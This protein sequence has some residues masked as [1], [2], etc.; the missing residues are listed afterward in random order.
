MLPPERTI[1]ERY[2]II[3]TVDERPGCTVYR[4]RDEQTNR[5]MLMA[6]LL[7]AP[8]DLEDLRLLVRQVVTVRHEMILP[9]LDHFAE[10]DRYYVVCEDV[11]GQDLERTLRAQGGP[12]SEADG[13]AQTRQLL[14]AL[15]YIHNQR[16]A[17]FLADPFTSDIL[18]RDDGA[19]RLTPFTMIRPLSHTPSPYRAPE[20]DQSE[21]EPTPTSDLYA[22]T[23][24]LYY[25]LTG[26]APPTPAQRQAGM[27]LTG[28]RSLNPKLASLTEQVVLRGL[29]LKPENR[30]QVPTEMRMSLDM[31]QLMAG[32]SLGADAPLPAVAPQLPYPPTPSA[33]PPLIVPPTS[34]AAQGMPAGLPPP[35]APMGYAAPPP[36][37]TIPLPE[38][39][40]LPQTGPPASSKNALRT[41]CLVA[42]A[43]GLALAAIA[44]CAA[45]AW[46]IPG[47]PLPGLLGRTAPSAVPVPQVAEATPLPELATPAESAA[48]AEAM[49]GA[50]TAVALP[51]LEPL[52]LGPR[53]IT[54]QSAAQITQTRV[55]TS[56][57]V[58]PVAFAPDGSIL[59]V[60]VSNVIRLRDAQTLADF[61][62]PR[63][64]LGHTGKLFTL[65]FSPDGKLLASGAID[66]NT[67][68]LW[69]AATGAQVRTLSGHN[70]WIRIVAF[71]PDGK[72]LASG[73]FDTSI[74]LW[75][76]ASGQLIRTLQ[77]HS[78]FISTV[79]FSPDGKFLASSASDGTVQMWDL[80][81]G[82]R[83]DGFSF[84]TTPNPATGKPL[85]TTGLA[86]SPDGKTLAVG[87]EDGS[88][89]LADAATGSIPRTLRGHTSI[90]V[91]RALQFSP[92]GTT[93]ASGS[94]DGTVRLWDIATGT[95]QAVLQG[96]GLRV[97][98]VAFSPDGTHLASTSD[99]G[100]QLLLWDVATGRVERSLR[101]GQGVVT[102]LHF[103]PDGTILG[104]V[105]YNGATHMHL[106]QQKQ[107]RTLIGSPL[108]LNSL[109]FLDNRHVASIADDGTV[110]LLDLSAGNG[111][112]LQGAEGNAVNLAAS[113]DGTLLA[114]GSD[115]GA[116]MRWNGTNGQPQPVLHGKLG[117]VYALAVS[118]DGG[119][120][121]AAGPARDPQIEIWDAVGGKLLH[122]IPADNGSAIA[123]VF[124]PRGGALAVATAEGKLQLW[125]AR[126]GALAQ[127][128][129]VPPEQGRF[130]ALAFSPDGT[131]LVTGAP[132]GE[133]T[134]W[135]ARSGAQVAALP[136]LDTNQSGVYAAAFS[137]D[138]QQL[139]LALGDQSLRLLS[140]AAGR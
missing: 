131:M 35:A 46:F 57:E 7:V 77:G 18:V 72:T 93:L 84:A 12:V 125:D 107:F 113:A 100:G 126:S 73:S 86:F 63:A 22:L 106:L 81:S 82:A 134:F 68:R 115:T 11:S 130:S 38:S 48:T 83:R 104:S 61:S 59:A 33:G 71:S 16:P 85:W 108:A 87:M 112:V 89:A 103:S 140:L 99:Q 36:G 47:S 94:F 119:L 78:G 62:P 69:D 98:A 14:E 10:D 114:A 132:T 95:Q 23:A 118:S 124:Q 116:I 70:D 43:L 110:A 60:G 44:I 129:T 97:L 45:L 24:L 32:R 8:A 28:P 121:A 49:P 80:L 42:F 91:S 40:P 90:V 39:Q 34:D 50:A 128:I 37:T 17:L 74:K 41:G 122:T 120:I 102:G 9:V 79:A 55:I 139:A 52:V 3:Y 66:E 54:L 136:P 25:A 51:T 2:R 13:L 109:V 1:H 133:L 117:F 4:V 20:L 75:D 88:I 105:G 92:D 111:N 135:E 65:A 29:Q 5:L 96:H 101:V 15:E 138:G 19:W 123:I 30:Y 21:A 64:L 67:V 137:A 26:W 53:A 56:E 31:V 127:T 27:P 6:S 76:V 58:G